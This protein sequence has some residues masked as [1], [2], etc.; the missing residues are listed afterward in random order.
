MTKRPIPATC[1]ITIPSI[2]TDTVMAYNTSGNDLHT[3]NGTFTVAAN[4]TWTVNCTNNVGYNNATLNDSII[5]LSPP[6]SP[7]EPIPE[8]STMALL[9]ALVVVVGGF[10]FFRR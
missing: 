1:R 3:Y 4:Y 8:F 6:V 7:A 9:V 5:V 10:V 2:T